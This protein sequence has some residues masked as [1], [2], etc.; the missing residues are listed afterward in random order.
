NIN[1]LCD[2]IF[3]NPDDPGDMGAHGGKLRPRSLTDYRYILNKHV[4]PALG[5]MKVNDVEAWHIDKLHAHV[6]RV[7]GPYRANRC[8]AVL[9]KM[10]SLAI[11]WKIRAESA[12]NP[13]KGVEKNQ[14]YPRERYLSADERIRLREALDAHDNQ[15]AANVIRLL[16]Y[17]GAR[18]SEPGQTAWS[19]V[20]LTRGVWTK[21][22]T[23]TKQKK[24]HRLPLS[25]AALELL[26]TMQAAAPDA[27]MITGLTYRQI[28]AHFGRIVK[29]AN[30]THELRT[31]PNDLRHSLASVMAADK[32]SL[33]I[34][35]KALGHAHAAT[36]QRYVHLF[37]DPVRAAT[38]QASAII[39]AK[40]PAEVGP[41]DGR[42][43]LRPRPR[44]PAPTALARRCG[45]RVGKSSWL[46]EL[47]VVSLGHGVSLLRRR[48]GARTP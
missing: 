12:G 30:L 8:I 19:D 14:E 13:C 4:R 41:L 45:L 42:G 36:T 39:T 5:T 11:R 7:S 33:P 48:S 1:A 3:G 34:I 21:I 16:A 46:R 40:A 10:F 24:I 44:P 43:R 29:A 15:H 2:Q 25:T 26:R 28:Y 20:D 17:T 6:T 31:R 35:G 27:R 22:A 47:E 18:A 23:N 32:Q 9:S 38:E 37:D